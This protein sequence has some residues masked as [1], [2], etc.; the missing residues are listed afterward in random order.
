MNTKDLLSFGVSEEVA[1]KISEAKEAFYSAN[2]VDKDN[3]S[4]VQGIETNDVFNIVGCAKLSGKIGNNETD[5]TGSLIF[6][7]G[8]KITP[9]IFETSKGR[10]GAKHFAKIDWGEKYPNRPKKLS[11]FD[12]CLTFGIWAQIENVSFKCTK[13]EDTK[14][15]RGNDVTKYTLKV[16]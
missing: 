15:K 12:D 10:I 2:N 8:F 4:V 9:C 11:T 7:N 6:D 14:D 1:T 5:E 3:V 16:M 13:K